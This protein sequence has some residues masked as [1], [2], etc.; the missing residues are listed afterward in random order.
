MLIYSHTNFF[1]EINRFG[2]HCRYTILNLPNNQTFHNS[3]R[4]YIY[5]PNSVFLPT[6]SQVKRIYPSSPSLYI[7]GNELDTRTI[8]Y[9]IFIDHQTGCLRGIGPALLNLKNEILPLDILVENRRISFSIIEV[10]R[11][12]FLQSERPINNF[13]D[14][15]SLVLKFKNFTS[16]VYLSSLKDKIRSSSDKSSRLTISTLQ[17]DNPIIWIE[18]WIRWHCRLYGVK[19]VVLYDNGSQDQQILITK[20]RNLEPEVEV[21][22]VHWEF[23]YGHPYNYV[24]VASLNHCRIYFHP[25]DKGTS[26]EKDYCINLDIDEYLVSPHRDHLLVYLDSIFRSNFLQ[27]VVVEQV[28]VTS[29]LP[30]NSDF[31]PPP[32]LH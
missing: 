31:S 7:E 24:Q 3:V 13:T 30:E 32:S 28:P 1:E 14:D 15:V 4:L 20:L 6:E 9:D 10:G 27:S 12:V 29:I 25:N 5:R 11:L 16:S 8:F 22:L 2:E 19:R 21:V 17:K 18:D 26:S 23:P